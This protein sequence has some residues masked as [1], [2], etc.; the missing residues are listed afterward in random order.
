MRFNAI[1]N[2]S[3]M[4]FSQSVS[5]H[6]I[7][8]HT[9]LAFRRQVSSD[10]LG[11]HQIDPHHFDSNSLL[12]LQKFT[13]RKL[14][15]TNTWGI[16]FTPVSQQTQYTTGVFVIPLTFNSSTPL[17]L[18]TGSQ[19]KAHYGVLIY[20]DKSPRV[21]IHPRNFLSKLIIYF[22]LVFP[23]VPLPGLLRY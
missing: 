6:S 14:S 17:Y 1:G 4:T 7:V 18:I 19:I 8:L 16:P 9:K 5:I 21:F 2:S 10:Q 23:L 13:Y 11:F 15:P 20:L 3:Y 12:N 22:L